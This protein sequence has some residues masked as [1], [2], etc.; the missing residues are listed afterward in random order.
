M[1]ENKKNSPLILVCIILAVLLLG[2]TVLCVI[3]WIGKNKA[4]QEALE[5]KTSYEE[6][7]KENED[8]KEKEKEE[9]QRAEEYQIAY[10]G[11]V[12]QMLEDAALAEKMGNL[13]VQ[14][15][16]N[17]IWNKDDNETD[18]FTKENGKFV[19]DFNVALANLFADE[20]FSSNC[21]TLSENQN[22]V[23]EEMKKMLDPPERCENSMKALENMYNSYIA[24]TNVVLRCDGS[25]ESF[26]NDFAEA[27][28]DLDKMY[29][30]AE[31]Y[32]KY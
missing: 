4:E 32:M 14:V 18:K 24:F 20:E 3:T 31:L 17:A 7:V 21:R 8:N 30:S 5:Y 13:T 12:S 26:S 29:Q 15:W 11:L 25:L 19:S 1:E 2:V 27:D 6:L 10:N 9:K 16:N 22:L 23:K 28:Q